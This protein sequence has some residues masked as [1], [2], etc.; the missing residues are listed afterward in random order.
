MSYRLTHQTLSLCKA[1]SLAAKVN[2]QAVNKQRNE[3]IPF[4]VRSA[5]GV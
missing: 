2:L 1:L 4:G 3:S 5:R